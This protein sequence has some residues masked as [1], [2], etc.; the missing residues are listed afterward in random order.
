[1]KIS[2]NWIRDFASP[3]VD[4][5]RMAD[6]LT[7]AGIAVEGFYNDGTDFCYEAEITTNRVD[8]MNHYGVARE[9]SAIYDL[10]LKAVE[11]HVVEQ[12]A[13]PAFP[14]EIEDSQGCARYT[15]RVVRGVK[16]APSPKHIAHRLEL[17]D[18]R[19]IS[20]VADATNYVLNEIG[21]PT[22]AFDLDRIE[23]GKIVVRRAKD[24]E[25]L[26][27]LDGL[28]RKLTRDDLVIADA[29]KPLALAGIMGG[30]SS[31]I[32]EATKNVLIESAW[33]DPATI[34]RTARRLGM[35]TDASHRFE[36]GAD[37]GITP[38]AC[39]RVAQLIQ[40]SAGG[41]VSPVNDA[42]ARQLA[43][44]KI[45]LRRS[46]VAR[47]LGADI[48][49]QEIG[50][51]LR[52]LG[53]GVTPGRFAASAA[54]TG[55]SGP[56]ATAGVGGTGAAVAESV[57]DF[58]VQVPSW[59]LDVEREIDLIEEIARIYGYLKLPS[60]LPSFAGAVVEL[61]TARKQAAMRERLLAMGYNES[62]SS[63]FVSLEE[64]KH[65]GG[66]PVRLANPLSEEAAYMR[67]SL[68]PNLISQVAY[69]LNRGTTDVRLFEAGHI[70]E[71]QGEKVDERSR[72]AFVATGNALESGVHGKPGAY[73]F[74]HL[75]GEVEQ[76]IG[77][78]DAKSIYYDR[79]VPEYYHPGRSAR[80]VVDGMTVARFGQ[81]HPDLAA[82][83]KLK[84]DVFVAE[85]ISERLF[86]H[87][88]R[89]PRYTPVPRFPAVE[90]DFS[91][92]L[93]E[94]T[95][96]ERIKSTVEALNISE[97]KALEPAEIF[98]G[99]SLPK[100]RYSLLLRAR[101]QSAERTLRDDEVSTWSQQVI[102]AV[103]TLGGTLRA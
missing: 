83:R 67:T 97:M 84:Q 80:V 94:G 71:A 92:L 66:E 87:N 31:M 19:P 49:E 70:F 10:E 68:V 37:F 24:G 78:F 13:V 103:E 41:E 88:L 21:Q 54:T 76:L 47:I 2:V 60:T 20:N 96:F 100:D 86:A 45:N 75:K 33:F 7:A 38:L 93:P 8:A 82:S 4:D 98:R 73:T 15:A 32:T 26:K 5:R 79:H 72:I 52:R 99:G 50:R 58:V 74:F 28:E 59:R 57:A 12:A 64:A 11:P 63:T 39:A 95:E 91:F 69:N 65:F 36:R 35:H 81:V 44:P 9:A 34:R 29:V 27:T 42:V 17:I 51:I 90:R 89:L 53:F 3:A 56:T 6:D 1:M 16:I 62:I 61:P 25:T 14:I 55:T 40:E 48:P 23:G 102:K 22:H 43:F 46:E 101:F 18:Q 85:L 30:E 77:E